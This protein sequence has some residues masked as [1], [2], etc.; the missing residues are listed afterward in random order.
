MP[1]TTITLEDDVAVAVERRRRKLNH[2]LKREVND[3]LRA[4]LA[5]LDRNAPAAP[6]FR[7]APFST[8]GLLVSIDDVGEALDIAEGQWR[9]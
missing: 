8:G 3:L 1:R 7:V 9:G 6:R 5:E 2:T 4:G